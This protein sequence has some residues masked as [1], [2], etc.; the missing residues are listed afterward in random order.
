MFSS[1]LA[2]GTSLIYASQSKGEA[3]II[4]LR[5]YKLLVAGNPIFSGTFS[6]GPNLIWME[7]D[8]VNHPGRFRSDQ[9]VFQ[10]WLS[11]GNRNE[12]FRIQFREKS[13]NP[14]S[15][16]H[17]ANMGPIWGRQD[18]GGPHVGPMNF[19]IWED[20]AWYI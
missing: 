8:D 18:P 20:I 13:K 6:D 7:A 15:K 9:F 5:T 17:G 3:D 2:H 14:D 1:V 4:A 19:A 11:R 12:T 16:V 10:L